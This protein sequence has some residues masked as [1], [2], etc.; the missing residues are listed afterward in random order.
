M[1]GHSSY[2]GA[3]QL[4]RR[5]ERLV[6][7]ALD[8][9]PNVMERR[10]PAGYTHSRS[11]PPEPR[12]L[13]RRYSTGYSKASSWHGPGAN[14]ESFRPV[15]R[16]YPLVAEK[17]RAVAVTGASARTMRTD[18]TETPELN[19]CHAPPTLASSVKATMS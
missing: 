12:C 4:P 5:Q 6:G 7:G 18:P 10:S 15:G 2:G 13:P 17:R 11:L 9:E 8:C 19:G 3:Q 16:P 1:G 14:A